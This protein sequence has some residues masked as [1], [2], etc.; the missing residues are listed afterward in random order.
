MLLKIS[1]KTPELL[2]EYL[3]HI[4]NA[5]CVMCMAGYIPTEA[6]KSDPER[7]GRFWFREKA[8]GS[9]RF[10][11]YPVGN[12]YWANV[13]EE[14]DN[15]IVLTF[16]YRYDMGEAFSNALIHLIAVRFRYCAEII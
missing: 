16:R 13:Q 15:F 10:H 14:G 11:L 8:H 7:S 1:A 12:D 9:N 5:A 3:E 4:M 2:S 6:D